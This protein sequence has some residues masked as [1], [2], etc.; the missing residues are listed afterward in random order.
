MAEKLRT[1]K[2]YGK[3]G[4][5]FGREY[6]LAVN[7]TREAMRALCVLVPGF[8]AYMMNA[9][10]KGMAFS[11]FIG[12]EN[13]K[14]DR[15]EYPVGDEPIRIAPV[16]MGSKRGGVL[17]IIVGVVLILIGVFFPASAPYTIPAGIGM[18]AGGVIQML[19]PQPKGLGAKDSGPQQSSYSFNGP[20]N[21][22]AQGNPVPVLYGRLTVGSA[23][24]SA[25]I[26]SEDISTGGSY[27]YPSGGFGRVSKDMDRLTSED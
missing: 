26:R 5:K 27:S 11:V 17:N 22:Q 13:I 7:S 14:E 15:L 3:L 1:I 20:V 12:K 24:I 16:M 2:L 10:D 8:E 25:G 19:S 9:K 4:A 21:T 6:R 23:V 18:V